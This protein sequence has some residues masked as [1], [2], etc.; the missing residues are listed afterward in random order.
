MT[1]VARQACPGLGD[2]RGAQPPPGL[3]RAGSPAGCAPGT[4][5]AGAQG[6]FSSSFPL[7]QK[8]SEE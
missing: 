8:G 7:L 3:P 1:S 6:L 5:L 2:L 4:G